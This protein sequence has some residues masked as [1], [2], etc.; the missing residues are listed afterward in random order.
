MS[1]QRTIPRIVI[2]GISSGSGKTTFMVGL[3]R[4][5]ARRGLRVVTFKTGPD[6]LDPS[7]HQR[8]TG[9]V[10]Q[11]L[12][13]WM[14][15]H[16]A[17]L[18]TFLSASGQADIALIEGVMGLFDGISAESEEGSTAQVAKWLDAPVLLVVDASGMARTLAAI[19]HGCAT[20]DSALKVAGVLVNR[21]GSRSHLDLL[22]RA[23]P[24]PPVVGGLP[25]E[26]ELAFAER[27][28]GLLTAT[29]SSVTEAQLDAWANKVEQWCDVDRILTLAR[30]ASELSDKAPLVAAD[31]VPS[32]CRIGYAL[33]AAFHFYYEDNLRRLESLGATLVPFSP[34]KDA[35]LPEVDGLYLG[36]GYPE[37]YAPALS[38]NAAMRAD[39]AR[40][41][42]SGAPIYGEC[43]GL[44]YLSTAIRTL[45]G[46]THPMVGLIAGEA[47]MHAR[48]QT[49]GYVEIVTTAQSI[50]G[51]PGVSFR[52]H[53][54]RYSELCGLPDT[55]PRL[56]TVTRR[57]TGALEHEGYASGTNVV[58]TYIHAHWASNPQIATNF[59]AACT[60][61]ALSNT[62]EST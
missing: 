10:S 6:Y 59:V 23:V 42:Q 14:M 13:G 8:A 28:L 3:G 33:D 41:A 49:L 30:T 32:K 12:D 35:R 9:R 27:H 25:K 7:Y 16:D 46:M 45:D 18:G 58:G 37:L 60:R 61:H 38:A 51:E 40:L 21:V 53:Q 39:I 4:A 31:A 62:G 36:G 47:V 2:A 11:N 20:F 44:M 34:I 24:T 56:Y 52:G 50:L 19:V 1:L 17:V 55:V 43:G 26:P 15:G 29:E 48:L 57:R 22:Q 5:L 54:F